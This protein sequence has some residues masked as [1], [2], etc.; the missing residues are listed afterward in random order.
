MYWILLISQQHFLQHAT[1][2]STLQLNE[3]FPVSQ[4]RDFWV[5]THAPPVSPSILLLPP[6]HLTPIPASS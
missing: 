1:L 5:F 3:T 2:S 4:A 6:V